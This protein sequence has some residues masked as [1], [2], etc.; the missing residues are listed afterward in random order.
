MGWVGWRGGAVAS[1]SVDLMLS[2]GAVYVV[3]LFA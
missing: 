1:A 3:E 2:A